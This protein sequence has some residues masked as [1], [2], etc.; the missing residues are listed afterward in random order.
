MQN[1]ATQAVHEEPPPAQRVAGALLPIHGLMLVAVAG[2]CQLDGQPAWRALAVLGAAVVDV[3]IGITLLRVHRNIV[4]LGAA[5]ALLLGAALAALL[6]RSFPVIS[7]LQGLAAIAL[8]V[9]L[10]GRAGRARIAVGTVAL[11]LVCLATPAIALSAGMGGF[12]L[13]AAILRTAGQIRPLPSPTV[14]GKSAAWSLSVPNLR[15]H[16][17]AEHLAQRDNPLADRWLI[18]PDLD[19][20]LIVIAEHV[21]GSIVPIDPYTDQIVDNARKAASSFEIVSREPYPAQ[22]SRG[23]LVRARAR[24][25]NLDLLYCFAVFAAYDRGFQVVAFAPER[26]FERAR[27]D[28][29]AIIASFRMPREATDPAPPQDVEPAAAGRVTGLDAPY[30]IE[31]PSDRWHLRKADAVRKDNPIIDRWLV[32]YESDAHV[33]VISEQVPGAALDVDRYADAVMGNL[34]ERSTEVE[35][36]SRDPITAGTTQGRLIHLR[37]TLQDKQVEYLYGVFAAQDRG[38]QVVAFAARSLFPAV[39]QDL[40]KTVASF[41]YPATSK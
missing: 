13:S 14:V 12:D 30:A 6:A 24:V 26:S 35:I 23:R 10:F 9:L 29:D 34:R 7:A 38:F 5:R 32:R 20:H 18:R 1:S 27:A 40:R 25:S 33:F 22:P 39:E 36:V 2:L 17:R 21:P 4:W 11:A 28:F 16:L 31:A 19:A 3:A 37:A 8:L 41:R 15:W